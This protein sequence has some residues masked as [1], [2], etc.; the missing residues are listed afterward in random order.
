M[1]TRNRRL[2]RVEVE[3]MG[4]LAQPRGI[5]LPGPNAVPDL[6]EPLPDAMYQFDHLADTFVLLNRHFSRHRM[7]LVHGNSPIY[8][9][10]VVEGVERTRHVS[11]DG[12][13]AFGVD[14]EAIYMRNGYFMRE[15]GRAPDFVLEIASV[16]TYRNDLG[17]K[18]EIYARL[19]VE[20][21]WRFDSK[22]GQYYGEP[23]VGETLVD[24]EYRRLD[25]RRESDSLVWGHSPVLGLD[26]CWVSGRLRFF[27][28]A[29]GDYLRDLA[30]AEEA[31]QD[32][33]SRANAAEA[34]L[35][36]LREELRRLQ[37]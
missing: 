32:A 21:Y 22:G 29:T 23:L 8:Y 2:G 6:D 26:L 17:P 9:E 12:Y 15:V 3:A 31:W 24:G 11:P 19:G 16:S 14:A 18:R 33:E 28:P 5:I 34:E 37:G 36:A 4:P 13:V 1:T 10:D 20:E 7:T 35:A 25:I 30:E 27:N